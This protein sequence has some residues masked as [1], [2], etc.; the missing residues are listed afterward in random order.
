MNAQKTGSKYSIIVGLPASFTL[1]LLALPLSHFYPFAYLLKLASL[2]IFWNPLVWI[3][4][5]GTITLSL[6]Q[7]GRSIAQSLKKRDVIKTS[8]YFTFLVNI[9]LLVV[10]AAI[11]FG[12]ILHDWIFNLREIFLP[13]IPYSI[14][15]M[16]AFFA[17]STVLFSVTASLIIVNLTKNKIEADTEASA[18]EI[19][20][21]EVT[22][23][24]IDI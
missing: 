1:C 17:I 2:R 16:L 4:L 10:T 18:L 7:S 20:P 23:P 5:L 13:A 21:V 6:W 8:F 15:S 3:I 9:K 22:K 19:K 12:G 11:Y 14:I 24:D